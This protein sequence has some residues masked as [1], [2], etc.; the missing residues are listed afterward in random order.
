[1]NPLFG[2]KIAQKSMPLLDHEISSLAN[3]SFKPPLG[4]VHNESNFALVQIRW[5]CQGNTFTKGNQIMDCLIGQAEDQMGFVF[6]SAFRIQG[7]DIRTHICQYH[8]S[9]DATILDANQSV[10]PGWVSN[11]TK[12]ITRDHVE[13]ALAYRKR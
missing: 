6:V 10:E 11:E 7:Q 1:M 4:A 8:E 3:N 13:Q 5:I 9:L 12:I 2:P